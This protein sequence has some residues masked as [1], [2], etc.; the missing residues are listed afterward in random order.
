MDKPD[1]DSPDRNRSLV[2][3]HSAASPIRKAR[4]PPAAQNNAWV[5]NDRRLPENATI[6]RWMNLGDQALE[7]SD[8]EYPN[9]K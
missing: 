4:R 6:R 8:E 5:Q 2:A 7:N 3:N 9:S 1:P